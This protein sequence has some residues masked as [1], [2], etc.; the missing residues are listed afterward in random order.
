MSALLV[1]SNKC[2]HCIDIINFIN[3]HKQ[4]SQLIKFHDV[5]TSGV[6]SQYADKINRVPTMLTTNGKIMVGNEVKQWLHSLL[7]NK[8]TN[9]QLNGFGLGVC[10][11]EGDDDDDDIFAL[12]NYGQSLQPALTPELQA[13]IDQSVGDA[14]QQN[15]R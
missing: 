8:L 3:Q 6:P 12:N 11:L 14:F 4:L 2:N 7:P 15:K 10:S 5:N 13:K 1:Y 9:H